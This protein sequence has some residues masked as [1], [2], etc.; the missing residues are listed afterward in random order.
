MS[1]EAEAPPP[2]RALDELD[3]EELAIVVS[4]MRG[5]MVYLAAEEAKTRAGSPRYHQLG[6]FQGK[7]RVLTNQIERAAAE[8]AQQLRQ[9]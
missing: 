6:D 7:C 3:A 8:K 4:A 1:A 9:G 5:L 2:G